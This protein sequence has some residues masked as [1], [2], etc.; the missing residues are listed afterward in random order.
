MPTIST[1][2]QCINRKTCNTVRRGL[3]ILSVFLKGCSNRLEEILHLSRPFRASY[4]RQS[5]Q[6]I[7]K[8]TEISEPNTHFGT[9]E[10][11][12]SSQAAVRA[13]WRRQGF[14]FLDQRPIAGDAMGGARDCSI[15]TRSCFA[16]L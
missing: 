8:E 16:D 9:Q 11:R 13:I 12:Q 3:G 14:G 15:G 2:I 1:V 4:A 5:E 6:K 10:R 7:E